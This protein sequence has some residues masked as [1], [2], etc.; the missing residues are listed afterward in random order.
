MTQLE[1]FDGAGAPVASPVS[2]WQRLAPVRLVGDM[3][4]LILPR[5]V[6]HVEPEAFRPCSA[7]HYGADAV[8]E[9]VCSPRRTWP[10]QRPSRM[11]RFGYG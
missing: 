8:A 2:A 10:E 1:L 3:R 6:A 11:P 9:L 5:S 7:A 4:P